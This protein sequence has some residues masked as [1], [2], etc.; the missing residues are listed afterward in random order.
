MIAR[1]D[2]I[3]A[4]ILFSIGLYALVVKPN[5]IKKLIGLNIIETSV[6]LFLIASGDVRL[7]IYTNQ[8][9][10]S[11]VID[12]PQRAVQGLE[13]MINPIP[14]ALVL[15]AIVVSVCVTAIALSVVVKLYQHYGT[16]DAREI[17]SL[18]G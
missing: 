9:A 15:T 8:W 12:N 14:S 16:L 11:N 5:L 17:A 18:K 7:G 1:F 10:A 13:P 3:A 4:V 6:Y 2:Y